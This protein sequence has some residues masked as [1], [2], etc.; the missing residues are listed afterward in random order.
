[1]EECSLS[2]TK[3]QSTVFL[4]F[5]NDNDIHQTTV[6]TSGSNKT[7]LAIAVRFDQT[8]QIKIT[9]QVKFHGNKEQKIL[10]QA[11]SKFSPQTRI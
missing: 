3:V 6:R 2:W 10:I 9:K 4:Q 7:M 1:M 5:C 11:A 8:L